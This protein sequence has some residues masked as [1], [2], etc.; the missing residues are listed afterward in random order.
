[1]EK[2]YGLVGTDKGKQS[3]V[4]QTHTLQPHPRSSKK[5]ALPF[6]ESAVSK[7]LDKAIF[8]DPPTAQE[9]A[10]F[11]AGEKRRK[12]KEK[13]ERQKAARSTIKA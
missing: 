8:S 11:F 9:E 7:A 13:A 10:D 1:V 4:K 6:R 2:L 3:S 5:K 12:K